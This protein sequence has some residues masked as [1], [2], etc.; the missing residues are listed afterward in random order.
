M[1]EKLY[2]KEIILSAM[3]VKD[4]QINTECEILTELYKFNYKRDSQWWELFWVELLAY[5]ATLSCA[6]VSYLCHQILLFGD[7]KL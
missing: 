7:L 6:N 3:Y 2:I 4:Y 1:F 5:E